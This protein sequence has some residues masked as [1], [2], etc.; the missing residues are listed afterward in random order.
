LVADTR[1]IL[2]AAGIVRD[3]DGTRALDHVTF[4]L[5]PGEVHALVGENAAGKSTLV[6]VLSG[7]QAPD[8]GVLR[9]RGSA[10]RFSGPREAER[11]G[12][13]TLHQEAALVP[14]MSVAR[15]LF[16][17]REPRRYGLIDVTRMNEESAEL[18]A[19]LGLEVDVR[20]AAEYYGQGVQRLLAI[21]RAL[22][23]DTEVLILDEP[24]E[25]LEPEQVEHLFT[26]I[27]QLRAQGRSVL[28][29][30]HRLA[31][32]EQIA[33]RVTVLRDGRV[34]HTGPMAALDRLRL[35]SLMLGRPA[36]PGTTVLGYPAIHP[37]DP[38]VLQASGLTS[39][40]RLANVSLD[41][42]PGEVLGLSG[43][44]GAGRSETAK[45]IA[46]ALPLESGRVTVSGK[47]LRRRSVSRAIRAGVGML[48]EN[49]ATE[50]MIGSLSLRDNIVLA[51]LPR[52]SHTGVISNAQ[53]NELVNTLVRKLRIKATSTDQPVDELSGGTQ[54]KVL[55]ARWLATRPLVLM[56]DEPTRGIDVGSRADLHEL[57]DD[58]AVDGLAVMLISSDLDEMVQ[59]CD[60]V[61]VLRDGAVVQE[62][63]GPEVTEQNIMALLAAD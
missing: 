30:S 41:I 51:A 57:I 42:R 14:Q 26:V 35:V 22:H 17:G 54:Q 8:K 49:R 50:G 47:D 21:A 5:G 23:S 33:N 43:L 52:L 56:L 7:V 53:V 61:I 48:P 31:E 29:V 44:L 36:R 40:H 20:R 59:T 46:G 1:P 32:I 62:L 55:L 9:V 58:L 19:R 34:V 2:E 4:T 63:T 27:D 16:L 18:V 10:M 28:Y 25:G 13:R 60:R 12:I 24:T 3:F 11:A 45:A 6:K 38:P 37:A 39:H 15:N